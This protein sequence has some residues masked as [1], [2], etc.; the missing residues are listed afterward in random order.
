MKKNTLRRRAKTHRPQRSAEEI[1]L[2]LLHHLDLRLAKPSRYGV[3][4]PK[5][6]VET[7]GRLLEA[8]PCGRQLRLVARQLRR[9]VPWALLKIPHLAPRRPGSRAPT[10][11]RGL[12]VK[13]LRLMN[14]SRC[15]TVAATRTAAQHYTAK[16]DLH[17]SN[18]RCAGADKPESWQVYRAPGGDRGQRR[19]EGWEGNGDQRHGGR[20][21]DRGLTFRA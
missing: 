14:T 11:T 10:G 5:A 7:R 20:G 19:G 13:L 18:D 3:V 15:Q 1:L 9:I 21:R 6:L 2:R 4:V 8:L 16:Q 17:D 12:L